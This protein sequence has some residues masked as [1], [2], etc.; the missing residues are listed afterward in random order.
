MFHVFLNREVVRALSENV[1]V[2][3]SA[4]RTAGQVAEQKV[5]LRYKERN[6]GEIEMRNDSE[7][8]YRE[9]RFNMLKPKVMELLFEKIPLARKFNEKVHVYGNAAKRFGRW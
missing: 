2:C 7:I 6:L 5:L 9:I 8:H 3:N 4:A 1:E